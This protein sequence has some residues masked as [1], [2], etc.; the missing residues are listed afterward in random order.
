MNVTQTLPPDLDINNIPFNGPIVATATG[1]AF[2]DYAVGYNLN[3]K[4]GESMTVTPVTLTNKATGK[5]LDGVYL[6]VNGGATWAFRHQLGGDTQMAPLSMSL[7]RP[8][9]ITPFPTWAV[10]FLKVVAVST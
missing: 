1:R 10:G 8:Q 2:E 6:A 3:D 4:Y 7:V 9:D 5:D